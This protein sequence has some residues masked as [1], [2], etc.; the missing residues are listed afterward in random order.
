MSETTRKTKEEENGAGWLGERRDFIGE[1]ESEGKW[2]K[3]VSLWTTAE[4]SR[5]WNFGF[6]VHK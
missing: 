3:L 1:K 4:T 2:G 5:K 6:Y